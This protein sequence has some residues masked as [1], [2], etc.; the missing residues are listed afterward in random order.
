[1][2]LTADNP[3]AE[4]PARII[5][6]IRQGI[7]PTNTHAAGLEHIAIH[8]R[9]AAIDHAIAEAAPGDAVV[10]AGKGHE[11]DQQVGNERLPFDDRVVARA[12][13]ERRRRRASLS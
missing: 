8:D 3:R 10:I 2:I 12:A 13:L 4:D 11:V 1:M 5:S 7:V 6:Q 9:A